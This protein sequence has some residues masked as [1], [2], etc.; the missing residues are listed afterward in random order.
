MY[1]NHE[2]KNRFRILKG[3][4]ISLVVASNLYGAPSGGTVVS[5]N[6]TISQSGNSTNINQSSNKATINW[7][8]FSIKS[9]ETVN[10]NQPNSNSVTLNRVIGNEKSVIDGSLNA[11]GQVWILN[12]NGTLFG[13]NAKV[14]TSGLLVTTKELSDEDFQKGNYNFKGDSKASIENQ[15]DI[16]L[17]DKAYA[18][19][20]AN[21]VI[22]NGTIKI[23]K[24]NIHL[25]GASDV[26]LTL[27]DNSNIS[28]K[29]NKG[30]LDSLVENN[31]LIISNGGNVYL[32]TNAKNELLKGVVN[33]S[34]IIEA[35]SL[36]GLTGK[37]ELFAHGGTT[38]VSGTITAKDGFVETSGKNLNITDTAKIE[39]SKW[40]LDPINLVIESSGGNIGTESVNATV[41]QN[42]LSSADIELQADQ[43]ITINENIT[44]N[45]AT[46]LKLTAGDEIYVNA[47][48]NNT[49]STTGGV[50]FN[51]ANTTDKVIFGI[52]GKVIVNNIYQLQWIN[53]ALAG[54]Y[55]LGSNIDA[56]A[57]SSWNSGAGF[58]PIGNLTNSFTGILDGKNY[59]ISDLYINRPSVHVGLFGLTGS[60]TI[61][62]LGLVNVD[63]T[64]DSSVGGFVG[65]NYGQ[66]Q[67][68]YV[69]GTVSGRYYVGGLVGW[70]SNGSIINSYATG[71]VDGTEEGVGGL[72]GWNRSGIINS[73]ASGTVSGNNYVGGLVGYNEI[74][75]QNSYYD[76]ETNTGTMVDSSYGK[77]KAEILTSFS[78]LTTDW[79]T[80][81]NGSTVS[82]YQILLLPYL[83]GVTRDEDK[84]TFTLFNSGYGTELNPYTITNWTQ[85]QNI[86][87]SNILTQNYYF[88]LLN[89]IDSSTTGYMGNS[90]LGWNP[91]GNSYSNFF[92]GTFDGL[93]NIISDLYINRPS[94]DIIGLFGFIGSGSTI[95][96]IGLVDVDITG[97][98]F[99]GGLVGDSRGTIIT[100]S[101][102]LGSVSGTDI[103]GGL[104]G[105]NADSGTITNSYATGTVSGQSSV[106][107]LV[108]GNYSS[109]TIT[110]SYAFGSVI[111]TSYIGGLVGRNYYGTITNSYASGTVSVG[112]EDAGGLFG[113]NEEGTITDSFYNSTVNSA[114]M[115][116]ST[117]GKTDALMRNSDTFVNWDISSNGGEDTVWRIYE[118]SSTPLLRSFL[119]SL[120][121]TANNDTKTYDATAYNGGNYTSSISDAILLGTATYSGTSQ[122]AINAGNYTV[123]VDGLYSNQQGYDISYTNG[124]LKITPKAISVIADN[125]TKTYGEANLDLT[126]V[127]NGLIDTD[128]LNGSLTTSAT[129]SSVVGNYDITQGT[130][131]NSN[132]E[133]SFTKGELSILAQ[134]IPTPVEPT[135]VEPEVPIVPVV[136]VNP[137]NP[138]TQNSDIKKVVD[139]IDKIVNV[140]INQSFTNNLTQNPDTRIDTDSN[141]VNSQNSNIRVLSLNSR[142]NIN[143]VGNGINL[144][145][146]VNDEMI[147]ILENV[148]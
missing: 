64:G 55:E 42:A 115:S 46:Q 99:V 122:G 92:K 135:P 85:L 91:L 23:H 75:T 79:G 98:Y 127:A 81:G 101:Y 70:N 104:V 50:Y 61:K 148:K 10:F 33:N 13:K 19:F 5:G 71:S 121:I 143:I 133:I 60:S 11:N 126:Y 45:Q 141:E 72:V 18:V 89:N 31:N 8:D 118:G 123:L 36:D 32:T 48:I 37:V 145:L 2:Y 74:P 67:N 77:T 102:V 73:Y 76:K 49:N 12:S 144:P 34:G 29:V 108:G 63:I 96:N 136:P 78:S 119:K 132:Y 146:S 43:D 26:S 53:T 95:K 142:Q 56:S 137:I 87:N 134:V 3:G 24:G 106:G 17:N 59:A 93:G 130:L 47:T 9:N 117:F 35:N 97:G 103:V 28:L 120:I 80:T 82:G 131:E 100:N 113:Y 62:N 88:S 51:A 138:E 69:I 20:L 39:T 21:S 90:G 58:V 14:N 16:N 84:S 94:S 129:N 1:Q 27:D 125:K 44:W 65:E 57:T 124:T 147:N 66:I 4:L 107:G 68:S 52:N 40:L 128:S 6:A 114:Y 83:V 30:V 110:N 54:K 111:G 38:N 25:V 86:N 140:P 105:Q 7:Q 139:S 116:D 112:L 15:G 41:I 109:G 22:N